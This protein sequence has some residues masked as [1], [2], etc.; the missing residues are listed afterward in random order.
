MHHFSSP[1]ANI[2]WEIKTGIPNNMATTTSSSAT[3]K[4]HCSLGWK[5]TTSSSATGKHHYS[6]REKQQHPVLPLA[7]TTT[8]LGE[9]QQHPVPPLANTTAALG[10]KQQHPV[11]PLANTTAALGE[12][13]QHPVL[14]LANTTTAFRKNNN[15]QFCHWQ[16]P[17]QPSGKTTTSSSATGKH[18]YSLQEKQQ[19]PVLPL[20]N[21]TDVISLGVKNPKTTNTIPECDTTHTL[22]CPCW[23]NTTDATSLGG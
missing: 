8:A 14:P 3:G 10:E 16:T 21:S 9:K 5:T 1:G 18:H 7:N 15:I 12:K 23:K 4:H 13:Q 19:H 6:L 17:L 22:L 11:L 2:R 20:T